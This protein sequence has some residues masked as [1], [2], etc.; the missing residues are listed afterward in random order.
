MT[1]ISARP[2]RLV[3]TFISGEEEG[4]ASEEKSAI[5]SEGLHII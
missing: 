4:K 1:D 2:E 5:L 3:F